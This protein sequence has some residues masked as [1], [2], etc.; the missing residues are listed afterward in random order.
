M[1]SESPVPEASE[2]PWRPAG[3]FIAAVLAF[4]GRRCAAAGALVASGA[5]LEGMGLVLLAPILS[6]V[7]KGPSTGRLQSMTTL[8]FNAVGAETTGERLGLL[9]AGFV[10]LMG[11]R[12]V[13]LYARDIALADLQTGFVEAMR[14]G[15]M[16]RL[17]NA[18]WSRIVVLRHA[19]VANLMSAEIQ[20]VGSA[21][22]FLLQGMVAITILVIQGSVAFALAPGLAALAAA[23]LL[24]GGLGLSLVLRRARGAGGHVGQTALALMTSANS[25]MGGLKAAA[26]QDAQHLFVAEF[27]TLQARMREQQMAFTRLQARNRLTFALGTALAGAA[28]VLVGVNVVHLQSAVLI[29]LILLFTRMAGPA[30]LINQAAQQ[31]FFALPAFEAIKALEDDLDVRPAS[32][33][34]AAVAPA[35]PVAFRAARYQHAGGGGLTE[36]S[37]TLEPGEFLGI[38]GPSGSGKTT[39]IDML[40]GLLPPQSGGITLDGEA[41]EGPM[42]GGWRQGI[43]YVAQDSFLF[44]DTV[45]RNLAW[46]ND[47]EDEAAMW[48][49]LAATGVDGVVRR[50]ERGLDTVVGERGTLMSGGERQRIAIA[51]ALLRSPRLL[52]LDEATNAIDPVSE[53][54]L[55]AR[56]AALEPRPMIIMVAHRAESLAHCDR[57]LEIKD[58]RLIA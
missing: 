57:V 33:L 52:V 53:A 21:A 1:S 34:T 6:L 37:V 45:R 46:G 3:R 8:L 32:C 2:S 56:L 38:A 10:G 14:N 28:I 43:A 17:A 24:V 58:G 23:M 20:R 40:V 55:L 9:L 7:M 51:R 35:G 29:T 5:L 39:F 47:V 15:V 41:L 54:D 31:F 4:G 30:L 18:S 27:E 12:A 11:L 19:R 44:H 50:L 25:F 26:A 22:H 48:R 49:A 16:H 13:V 36:A 42:L